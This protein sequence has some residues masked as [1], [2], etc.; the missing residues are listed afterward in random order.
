[1]RWQGFQIFGDRYIL[2]IPLC[3]PQRRNALYFQAT[4]LAAWTRS[5]ISWKKANSRPLARQAGRASSKHF[6]SRTNIQYVVL[7]ACHFVAT[8]GNNIVSKLFAPRKNVKAWFVGALLLWVV[9]TGISRGPLI[10]TF[11]AFCPF[12]MDFLAISLKLAIA[13]LFFETCQNVS[14]RVTRLLT[15]GKTCPGVSGLEP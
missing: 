8:W 9:T 6:C 7:D 5:R 3:T 4:R 13:S 14:Q 1:M 12:V 11:K 10:F 2:R 15:G